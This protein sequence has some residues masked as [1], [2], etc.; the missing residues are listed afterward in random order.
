MGLKSKKFSLV[1]FDSAFLYKTGYCF[2]YA[3]SCAS[4]SLRK[5]ILVRMQ[6][7]RMST[8]EDVLDGSDVAFNTVKT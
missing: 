6:L 5:K 2:C 7:R 3:C 1:I 8:C 4:I